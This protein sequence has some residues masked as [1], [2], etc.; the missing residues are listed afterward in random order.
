MP[1][2]AEY[3]P[4]TEKGRNDF[5]HEVATERD[6]R[7]KAYREALKYYSGEH[8]NMLDID[9]DE[10]NDNTRINLVKMTA[11]RTV[12]FLFPDVPQF[13]VDKGS[14][15]ETPDEAW[16]REFFEAS[17]GLGMLIKLAL[18]GFLSG[19]GF[20]R[21]VPVPKEKRHYEKY[22]KIVNL[23]PTSVSVFWAA[24]DVSEVLWYEMRYHVGSVPYVRDFVNK[25]NQWVI[26]T[27]RG[28]A[29]N[30]G[31]MIVNIP[32]PH[33]EPAF[34]LN[35]L[36]FT[37]SNFELIA[38]AIHTSTI[39]PI[40]DFPHLPHPDDY[41]GLGEFTEKDLQDMVNRINSLRNRIVREHSEPV[42]VLTGADADDIE[43]DGGIMSISQSDARVWRMEM[44]GDLSGITV[45]LD[46]LIET[47][48]AIARVVL[49]K[50]EAKD[51]QRVTNA[52]VRT[53]FLDSI[54]KNVILQSS[55]GRALKQVAQL[56]LLMAYKA[57]GEGANP[58]DTDMLVKFGSALPTDLSEIAIINAQGLS[59]GYMSRRTA[60]TKLNLNWAEEQ[61]AME[62]EY[63]WSQ[64]FVEKEPMTEDEVAEGVE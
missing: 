28:V 29:R 53:L 33:G 25:G 23:D 11:D 35:H 13:K 21:V 24:D 64:Q 9:P 8:D 49:L 60:A 38:T 32:T 58:K 62:A 14:V 36:T 50:G 10:P 61:E 52:A 1:G 43:D 6:T 41:Y 34:W 7:R 12:S 55:Y 27:Y 37:G 40:I 16:V 44:K 2:A 46:K 54:S 17:G 4:A 39:P 31:E 3:V 42:D 26:Y 57:G 20:L 59:G 19:H 22:P 18:R 56:G 63:E 48:L 30:D 47:Y 5:A 45:V 51:L 15:E